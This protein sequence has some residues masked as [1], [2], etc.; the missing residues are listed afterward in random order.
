[1]FNYSILKINKNKLLSANKYKL[2]ATLQILRDNTEEFPI[3]KGKL[4]IS[5][6]K[7]DKCIKEYYNGPLQEH[8]EVTKILQLL[9]QYCQFLQ[10]RQAV[11]TYIKRYFSCQQNK[12]DTHASYNKIQYQKLFESP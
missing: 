8:S 6:D 2:N 10:I 4:Q 7:I 9:R 5:T 11:E 1:M 12:Y 3:E